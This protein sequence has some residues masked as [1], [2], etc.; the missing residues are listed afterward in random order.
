MKLGIG[1]YRHML[2]DS[3]FDFARQCGCT[4]LVVHL[5]DYYAKDKIVMATDDKVNYGVSKPLEPIW[6][7]ESLQRLVKAAADKEL[8]IYAIENFSP[9]DWYDVL[10]D[11]PNKNTQMENLKKI[12]RNVGKAGIRSF[13]YNFSLAGVWG[14]SKTREGRGGAEST[15]FDAGLLDLQAPIPTGEVWNMTYAPADG[16][17]I[18]DISHEELWE[19]LDW[20]LQ[21]VIP[22]AEEAGVTMALHPDDPPMPTLRGTPRLVYQPHM[23]QRVMDLAP[24]PANGIDF[25]M[26]SIQEMSEGDIYEALEAYSAA[27]KIAY[28]HVR[29]VRG[30]VPRYREVFVDEGDIDISRA[31]TILYNQHFDGVLVPD[32]TPQMTCAAGWHAGMAFAL[33]Y[34]RA[35]LQ[36]LGIKQ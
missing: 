25:C 21:R 8:N 24:S 36:R 11:G 26:G 1:L 13:G 34:I 14:H 33:G 12:I 10:L 16:T 15:A 22:V 19:R 31:L 7:L 5:S 30:K 32:H 6:E 9:A 27:G 3:N 2:S 23:Y 28:V 20:F 17:Y 18:A 4:D 35:E 29:N